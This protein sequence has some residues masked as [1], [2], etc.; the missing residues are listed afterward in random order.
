MTLVDLPGLTR[1]PVG[2]QPTDIEQRIREMALEYI[3][4]YGASVSYG[5]GCVVRRT[6]TRST[7][8]SMGCVQAV[9]RYGRGG[10]GRCRVWLD[11]RPNCIILAVTP[12]NVDLATSDALQLAQARTRQK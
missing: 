9:C 12:A 6:E 7:Q 3:R 8:R 5:A 10:D 1:V 4:R 11:R 2:D